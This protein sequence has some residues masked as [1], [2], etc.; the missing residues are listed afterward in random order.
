MCPAVDTLELVARAKAH[1]RAAMARL[2]D[3]PENGVAAEVADERVENIRLR[4]PSE[5]HGHLLRVVGVGAV[6]TIVALL[7]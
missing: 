2:L 7:R 3:G 1:A 5:R 6:R 4:E